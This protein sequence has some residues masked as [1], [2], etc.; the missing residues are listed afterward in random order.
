M[1]NYN[2][3]GFPTD[4]SYGT[5]IKY[6]MFAKHMSNAMISVNSSNS[7]NAGM[8]GLILSIFQLALNIVLIFLLL[9]GKL[10]D[11]IIGYFVNKK[12]QKMFEEKNRRNK[13]EIKKMC[14]GI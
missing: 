4:G 2:L 11:L 7:S 13:E 3:N 8:L 12:R 6:D 14:E 9:I 5:Q 1:N 10:L